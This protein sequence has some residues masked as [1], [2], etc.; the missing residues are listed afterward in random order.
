MKALDWMALVEAAI[1]RHCPG[2]P[3]HRHLI[4]GTRAKLRIDISQTVLADLFYREETGRTDYTLI[5]ENR[6]YYGI[7][8]LGGWHEHPVDDPNTHGPIR[9]LSPDEAIALLSEALERFDS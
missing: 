9:P 1:D 8:N 7:D 4:R 5:V 6:R 2:V 3:Y